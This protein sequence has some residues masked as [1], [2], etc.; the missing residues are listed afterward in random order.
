MS[1]NAP[2]QVKPRVPE[3]EEI[4]LRAGELP[5]VT[6]TSNVMF[7]ILAS[8]F[9]A[10]RGMFLP[11]GKTMLDLAREVGDV[12]N[13]AVHVEVG[14]ERSITDGNASRDAAGWP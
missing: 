11:A 3:S 9:S 2:L 7:K 12:L 6:M 14:E 5:E 4:Y 10:Q 13:V 1:Q 8:E